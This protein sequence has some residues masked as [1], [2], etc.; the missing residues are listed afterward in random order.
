MAEQENNTENQDQTETTQAQTGQQVQELEL[1]QASEKANVKPS[2]VDMLLDISMPV[3]VSLGSANVPVKRLLQIGPG[4]VLQ[5]DKNI[6]QPA[7]LYVQDVKFATGD[8]VAV[9]DCFA[10][11]IREIYGM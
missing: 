6:E 4:S 2:G 8:I 1:S 10:I 9:D 7:E 11:R 5:L 3:T